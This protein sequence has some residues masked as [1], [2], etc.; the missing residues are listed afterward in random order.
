MMLECSTGELLT[1]V[2]F[3]QHVVK[4]HSA[5][6]HYAALKGFRHTHIKKPDQHSCCVGSKCQLASSHWTQ[7]S[8][9]ISPPISVINEVILSFFVLLYKMY[10][11]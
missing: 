8:Q 2:A 3:M 1:R 5:L 9:G 7:C 6:K 4:W 11:H 10:R